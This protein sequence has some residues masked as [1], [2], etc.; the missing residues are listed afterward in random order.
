MT[1]DAPRTTPKPKTRLTLGP[2][3]DLE[4]HLP[5]EWWRD[6][7]TS[8][9]LKTDGDVVEN[10]DATRQEVDAILSSANL[11]TDACILDLCC[12]QGRHTLELA[13]RGFTNLTGIDRSR[14]LIRLARRRAKNEGLNITFKEGEARNVRVPEASQ[15]LVCMMG[16]S[17]GYF[18][19]DEDDLAVLKS[20]KAALKPGGRLVLDITDGAWMRKHYEARTWEWIDQNQ[21]VCRER[22]ISSSGD[23]LI[24]REVVSHAERGVIA[25][26]LYAE[27]LYTRDSIT[28]LLERAGFKNVKFNKP[29]SGEST[30]GH[31][32]GMMAQ[33]FFITCAAPKIAR[34]MRAA[35]DYHTLKVC[36]ALGDPS[37]PDEIKVNGQ[38]NAE[39][40]D[41][42]ARLKEALSQL[43][44]Y[45]FSYLDRHA[46]FMDDLRDSTADFVFNLCDEGYNN[47]AFKELHVPA[48]LEMIGT[49]YSG[50]GPA[51]LGACYDKALVR[52]LAIAHNIPV[53]METYV[54]PGDRMATI[55]SVFP[56]LLK[57]ATG[58]SSIGIT[59]DAVVHDA[60]SLI[61]YVNHLHETLPGRPIL[62][63]EF[64]SGPEYSVALIGNP[65]SGLEPLPILEVD[66]SSL[67][68]G[69][70][71]ILG[72]ESKWQ[73]DSAY[74]NKVHFEE[75]DLDAEKQRELV[76]HCVH[77]FEALGCRDY[78]RFD[79]RTDAHG[80]IKLLEVNPNP[81][82][83][84]DGKLNLMAGF[85]GISY[86]GL[87]GQILKAAV[88]RYDDAAAKE[89]KPDNI[90][91]N[92]PK[93][94]SK[95]VQPMR[96]HQYHR[97]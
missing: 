76:Q 93:A 29:I 24:S 97:N 55:P 36:V 84:W 78:A 13:R 27:R 31:D 54:R 57:P 68:K 4:P 21:F 85:A 43:D 60:E 25:D 53:P 2:L 81:G 45:E 87:L 26:Q 94:D 74:W 77:L 35:L 64:L 8:M 50:A 66:Y 65:G 37:L 75:T 69:L 30:R 9:Y 71:K 3:A 95:V 42:I 89:A 11:A 49:P 22:S 92:S 86:A 5:S 19:R 39:D 96:I 28:A 7:F 14:Y 41:T 33:R 62:V 79:F 18:E 44:G 34:P 52:S 80:E 90:L 82:W 91:A 51:C 63:Q 56:A 72:Y 46:T 47:D 59:Q 61:G 12:G 15:D 73:P 23:R 1:N 48:L 38:F 83:C 40:F 32:L 6:L 10:D 16:N 58:D 88:S 67:N 20:V 17:F 70:P